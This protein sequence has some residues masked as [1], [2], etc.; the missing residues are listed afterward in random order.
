MNKRLIWLAIFALVFWT[1]VPLLWSVLASFKETSEVYSGNFFPRDPTLRAWED[2]VTLPGF[3][4]QSFNS[5]YVTVVTT[6]LAGI[7]S[8]GAAYAFARYAF[9]FRNVLLLFILIPRLVPRV[10]L[11]IPLFLMFSRFGLLDTYTVLIVTYTASAIPLAT[12]ILI[13]FFGAIPKEIEEAA[14]VDGATL[15]QRLFKIVLPLSTPGLVTIGVLTFRE[16]WNEFPYA[17]AFLQATEMRTL[18]YQLFRIEQT[19]GLVDW[20]LFSAFTLL[21]IIPVIVLYLRFE[22]SIVSSLTTGAVK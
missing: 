2:V 5:L 17:L 20:P 22:R 19:L 10:A 12:W 9:R 13:G 7:I 21:T 11:I 18:P 16:S 14:S 1:V 3:W 4:R 15:R 6:L 8:I